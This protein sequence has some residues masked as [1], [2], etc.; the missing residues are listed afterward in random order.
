MTRLSCAE[1]LEVFR[2]LGAPIPATLGA[3]RELTAAWQQREGKQLRLQQGPKHELY[4]RRC[5]EFRNIEESFVAYQDQLYAEFRSLA[6]RTL[7]PQRPSLAM[8]DQLRALAVRQLLLCD[9]LLDRF[10]SC[11]VREQGI[12]FLPEPLPTP[13]PTA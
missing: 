9:E 10:L 7:L 13:E 11:L 6:Q 3:F 5:S 4:N 2:Q 12:E 8:R 1:L